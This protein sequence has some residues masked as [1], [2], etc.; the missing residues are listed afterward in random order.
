[1]KPPHWH[2]SGGDATPPGWD[3]LGPLER[4]RAQTMRFAKRRDEFLM[5]RWAAKTAVAGS[6]ADG[7]RPDEVEIR[8][9]ADGAPHAY[10]RDEPWDR[11]LSLTDRAD[12]AVCLV[13][14]SQVEVG[15]DLE[16]VEARSEG[17]VRD[18]LTPAE[19]DLV[20]GASGPEEHALR[21]NLVWSAK[22]SA[23]KVLRTGLRRSTHSVEVT[24][25]PAAAAD[26]DGWRPL[27]V[28][29]RDGGADFPGWWCRHGD[30]LLTTC[31]QE[32]MPAPVALVAPP[33]LAE[34][35]PTHRWMAEPL[36]GP[37]P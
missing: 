19:Q 24:L 18:W 10:V 5:A 1:M 22:E 33:P 25:D 23:L 29:D 30:F 34:A 4:R 14:P 37:R 27:S 21:A 11:R 9:A 16:L 17:F 28:R 8:H 35:V 20:S 12:W 7:T 15:C 26:P 13:S 32:P 36:G 31:A 6:L 3:W 2:S